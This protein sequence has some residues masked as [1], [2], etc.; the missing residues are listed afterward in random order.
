[1]IDLLRNPSPESL[2]PSFFAQEPQQLAQD[3]LGKVLSVNHK[4]EWLMA[5]IIETEAYEITEKASHSS[6]GYTHKRRALFNTPGTIYMYYARGRDSLNF[7]AE[8]EGNAVLIKSALPVLR[9]LDE[10]TSLNHML[11]NNPRL[12][13][14]LR[15]PEYLCSGQTLLCKALGLRVPDWDNRRL[16]HNRFQ[17]ISDDYKPKKLIQTM[18]LGI[19][20]G[21]D[22][23]LFYR[24]IDY[25]FRQ[26]CTRDPTRVRA[27]QSGK[28]YLILTP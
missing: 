20:K 13:G 10:Q 26:F 6:L 17:L 16:E 11:R 21:R 22:E 27:W 4:G 1:M 7:S 8:G 12:D 18:R 14:S 2:P 3:L 19:P 23:H 28:Q 5:R 9:N 24:F 25:D 15:N